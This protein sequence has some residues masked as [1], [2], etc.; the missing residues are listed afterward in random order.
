MSIL[1]ALTGSSN[2]GPVPIRVVTKS[3]GA[4]PSLGGFP[5]PVSV[6]L[7]VGGL[8]SSDTTVKTFDSYSFERNL[9]SPAA[10]FRFTAPGLDIDTR[11]SIR[12]GDTI[13][14]IATDDDGN[15]VPVATGFI[16]ETD[17]HISPG[18]VEYVITGRD[19][20]GQLID[21]AAVDSK[22]KIIALDNVSMSTI[23]NTLIS[24][25]RMPQ[26]FSTQQLDN[27]PML[28]QTNIGETKMNAL[29]RYLQLTNSLVWTDPNG[30]AIIGK[31][32]CIPVPLPIVGNA[33]LTVGTSG[34]VGLL[35]AVSDITGT[36][37]TNVL[38]CRVRRNVNNAIRQIV[39]QMQNGDS[40][41]PGNYTLNNND[42]DMTAVAS[43]GVGRSVYMP[44]TFSAG[45]NAVNFFLKVA[46]IPSPSNQLGAALGYREIARENVQI[47]DVEITVQ[48]HFDSTGELYDVDNIY[49]CNIPDEKISDNLYCYAVTMELTLDHGMTTKLKLCK[50]GTIVAGSYQLP[51]LSSLL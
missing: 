19:T 41:N 12:S 49:Y 48:G 26:K 27:G 9:L 16:D 34:S 4:S 1:G 42:S 15:D 29:Q 32:D 38:D 11:M 36:Q 43:S 37:A 44:F 21:N 45:A 8:I 33:T 23:F 5:S 30:Q 39:V 31:P 2:N 46:N 47:L 25:T 7:S 51:S 24:N 18:R 22:N 3:A 13:Q 28:F 17:T 14:L 40:W 10:P 35:S 50:M 20:L 6:A